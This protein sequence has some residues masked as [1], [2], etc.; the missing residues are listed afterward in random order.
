MNSGSTGSEAID[1]LIAF[2]VL[3]FMFYLILRNWQSI[4]TGIVIVGVIGVGLGLAFLALVVVVTIGVAGYEGYKT[5]QCQTV[6]ERVAKAR[7][8]PNDYFGNKLRAD[9]DAEQSSC[10]ELATRLAE[11]AKNTKP[12]DFNPL[13]LVRNVM[14]R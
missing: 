7:A 6:Y 14:R 10:N 2:I 8:A 12:D 4:K 5:K 3:A 1:L 13:D 9:A 11:R